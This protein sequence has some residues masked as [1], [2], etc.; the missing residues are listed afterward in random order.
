MIKPRIP[1]FKVKGKSH[2]LADKQNHKKDEDFELKS[3][4]SPSWIPYIPQTGSFSTPDQEVCFK[5]K[6]KKPFVNKSMQVTNLET[7]KSNVA[8]D[9]YVIMVDG[10]RINKDTEGCRISLGENAASVT[11]KRYEYTIH[12][13]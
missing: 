13:E 8:D 7:L 1:K 11:V 9:G 2:K 4:R 5:V 10:E 6:A 3:S 12:L